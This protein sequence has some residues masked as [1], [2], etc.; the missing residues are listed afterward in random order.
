M[1]ANT[2][3]VIFIRRNEIEG[4]EV[5]VGKKPKIKKRYKAN[6]SSKDIDLLLYKILKKLTSKEVL[7]LLGEDVTYT[8]GVSLPKGTKSKDVRGLIY[9]EIKLKFPD[10]IKDSEWDY[11]LISKNK[12]NFKYIAFAPV[13]DVFEKVSRAFHKASADTIAIEPEVVAKSRNSDPVIGISLKDDIKGDDNNILSLNLIPR[14]SIKKGK[15]K[16]DNISPLGETSD[17][18][19]IGMVIFSVVLMTISFLIVYSYL[20]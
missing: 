8:L 2:K 3:K 18:K 4:A 20:N 14:E 1:F 13:N 15:S 12:E 5:S 10:D 7:L 6:W 17:L 19:V 11:K 9:E 16:E